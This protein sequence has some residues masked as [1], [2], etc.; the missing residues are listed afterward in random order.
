MCKTLQEKL[1]ETKLFTKIWVDKSYMKDNMIE[2]VAK[3]MNESKLVF[4]LL[5][6]SYCQSDFCRMEWTYAIGEKM[7]IYVAV[8]QEDFKKSK[9]DWARFSMQGELYFKMYDDEDFQRLIDVVSEFVNQ[10]QRNDTSK[11]DNETKLTSQTSQ[12]EG[13][14]TNREY[15]EKRS[16]GTWT[17]EDIRNWCIDKKLEKW[18][19]LLADFDGPNL[20]VLRKDL[21]KDSYVQYVIKGNSLDGI[22]VARFKSE[23]DKLLSRS[24]TTDESLKSASASLEMTKHKPPTAKQP[25]QRRTSKSTNK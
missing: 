3:A 17:S 6:D 15:L 2:T 9:Y 23:V 11:R 20:L 22:D 24:T 1:E 16:I 7:K 21:S 12:S 5:S 18:R 8:V 19:H 4:V 13:Q 10:Q 14:P 25:K